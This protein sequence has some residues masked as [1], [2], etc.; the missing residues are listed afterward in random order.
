MKR[1]LFLP[2]LALAAVPFLAGADWPQFRGT[3]GTATSK[4]SH[5]PEQWDKQTNLVWKA[6]LPGS[7]ASSPIILGDRVY[8]TSY[9][10]YGMSRDNP[11]SPNQLARHLS[12]FDRKEGTAVWTTDIHTDT[13]EASYRQNMQQHGYASNTPATDGKRLYV[14]LGTGGVH[15]FDL[16]GKEIWKQGVG[17][18]TDGWGSAS[19]VV[20]FDDLV[21][22]NAAVESGAIVAL[23]KENGEE[24]WR[25]K[26]LKKTWGT[27]ALVESEGGKFD[28]VVS[29]EK[30]IFGLDPKTGKELW[31]CEGIQDYVCPSVVAGKNV[32]YVCG[33]RSSQIIAVRTGGSGDVSQ[34]HVLWRKQAGGNVPTPVLYDGHLFGA[35]DRGG[36]A[37]CVNAETGAIDYQQRL[38]GD[39]NPVRPA[40]FQPGGRGRRGGGPGGGGVSFYASA[41]AADGKVFEVSRNSGVFVVA[42]DP[43]FELLARNEFEG[44]AGPFDGTP[45]IS[46]GQLFLRSNTNLYCIAAE[47]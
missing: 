28:L 13:P 1:S 46:D 31:T 32:A 3:A 6:K 43:K 24:A 18:G 44:D 37:F 11:G 29:S 34:S 36:I 4:D 12:C 33:G 35:S 21:I 8:V 15:A 26:G 42:A 19:S 20:L 47:K 45:A 16:S 40:A 7:G 5:L 41:V 10:G 23:K 27:P 9:S 14:F 2:I 25:F 38:S 22:V 30:R 39:E 17:T